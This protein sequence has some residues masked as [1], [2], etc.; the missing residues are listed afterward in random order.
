MRRRKLRFPPILPCVCLLL[1]ASCFASAGT[2]VPAP[3]KPATE[4]RFD[5]PAELPRV[6]VKSSLADTP[7]PGNTVLVKA[8]DNLQ[9]AVDKAKCGDT[10]K[11]EAG[12]VF[13]GLLSFAHK[14]CDDSHWITIRTSAPDEA[15]PPEGTRI[16][17]C[18]AG[19]ASLPG[20]PDF[21]CT[22]T[23]NVMA[24]IEFEAK[25]GSGPLHFEGGANH[26]RFIGLEITRGT[27]GATISALA[28]G[29]GDDG[30]DHLVF[31]RVWMHGTAQDETTRGIGLRGMTYVAVVDSF[32]SDFHCIAVVGGCIDSQALGNGGFNSPGGPYKIVNNF[33]EASG[34][35]ILFGGS[36]AT[37]VPADIEIRR[38]HLFKPMVWKKG[39]PGFVG[40][41]DGH[42]FIVKNNFELKSGQR[43]L[44]EGNILEGS[45]GGFSQT[46]F[47]ILL[48]PKNQTGKGNTAVCPI[49]RVSDVTI[50][51][52]RITNVA[53]VLQIANVL[54]DAG[55]VSSG[56]ERYS[57]HDLV[58]D[59][60]HSKDYSGFGPF[61]LLL[62]VAPPLHD[63]QISHVTAFVP[64][65]LISITH[66]G[67]E[68]IA[69][70]G[71]KDSILFTAGERPSVFSAGGG[72]QNCAFNP[73]M[74][75]PSGVFEHCFASAKIEH[76]II[77]GSDEKWPKGNMDLRD[78]KSAGLMSSQP[79]ER[80]FRLCRVAD[81][82]GSCKKPSPAL[83]A[84]SDGKNIGADI[85]A[86]EKATGETL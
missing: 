67:T 48:T 72:Q 77:I 37:Q 74:Q 70:F 57:I 82:K 51:Y 54:S 69:N 27:P 3:Q 80:G 52:N 20:R 34:E 10:L 26:Y 79:G 11:L 41:P 59:N 31:D 47:A 64:G 42:P 43:V 49:C 24:R 61:L 78:A 86:I 30:A 22:T 7:S 50:R 60:V 76:N 38:N 5:G 81:D 40:G 83:G 36:P 12:A 66:P 29:E 23:R 44:F 18:Y 28:L 85:E 84:A 19:V 1:L 6:Y 17:P 32:F 33:L 8:T 16:S 63:L 2:D 71:L 58:V 21:H 25:S 62:S 45:W 9:E 4:D 75:G 56:G 65:A 39:E 55:G 73:G 15:L 53:G 14:N 68:G 13:H 46:G 35:N